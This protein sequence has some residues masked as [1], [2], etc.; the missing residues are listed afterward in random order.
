MPL[1]NV[2][3][4]LDG[5]LTEP[6]E[7]ITRCY[8][9]ALEG[10]GLP[11]RARAELLRFIGPPMRENFRALLGTDDAELVERAVALYRERYARE[12]WRENEVYPGVQEMLSALKSEG[13]RLYVATSKTTDFA[14]RILEHFSLA[15]FF[16]A[17]HG[18]TPDG[19]LDDK[20][21]LVARLLREERL[22]AAESFMIGDREH[23]VHAARQNG[24]GAVGVTYGYGTRAELAAAGADFIRDSPPEV[25]TLALR[26][27]RR[28]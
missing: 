28:A 5:T 12:G 1:R 15:P 3:F 11:A 13:L 6:A 24:V 18:A 16:L 7:G 19:S 27:T 4:D 23:D 22:D 2:L 10:L 17:V 9:F 21:L 8:Q 25:S 14:V 26:L 20:A